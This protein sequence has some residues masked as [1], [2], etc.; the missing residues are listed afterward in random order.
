MLSTTL[1]PSVWGIGEESSIFEGSIAPKSLACNIWAIMLIDYCRS[2]LGSQST[3]IFLSNWSNYSDM[4]SGVIHASLF[5]FQPRFLFRSPTN[6]FVIWP[7]LHLFRQLF[8]LTFSLWSDW[9]L[10]G[11]SWRK[12]SLYSALS[13]SFGL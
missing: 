12:N 8:I 1:S 2:V 7:C 13:A 10:S 3:P 4:I 9:I 6:L 5:D 11:N